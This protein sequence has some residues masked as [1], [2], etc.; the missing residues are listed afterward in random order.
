MKI[1]EAAV[2]SNWD[3]CP[4]AVAEDAVTGPQCM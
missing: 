2:N 1:V 3:V 4:V